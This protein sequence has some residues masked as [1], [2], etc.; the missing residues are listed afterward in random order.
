MN[1]EE[2]LTINVKIQSAIDLKNDNGDSV[3]MI[4]FTGDANSRY[5]EGQVLPGGIDTQ[6]IG[7][8]GDRHTLSAR[9][10]L[11]GKDY[12]GEPC[13]MFIENNGNMNK[14]LQGALFRTYPKIITDSKALEFMNRD[15]L[16]GEGFSAEDGVKIVIYRKCSF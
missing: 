7:K 4:S 14:N 16:V 3:V 15:I 12:T 6:I 1:F 8:S 13:K 11:E 10:M 2:I 9:Y 5:F